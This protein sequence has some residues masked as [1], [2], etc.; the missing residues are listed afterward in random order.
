MGLHGDVNWPSLNEGH[1][2]V[3]GCMVL[4]HAVLVPNSPSMSV[5][6]FLPWARCAARTRLGLPSPLHPSTPAPAPTSSVPLAI[7]VCR[8]VM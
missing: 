7:P 4:A 6:P 1:A 3:W 2:V 5:V 8:R